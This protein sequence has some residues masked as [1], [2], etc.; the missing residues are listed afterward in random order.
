M[1]PET[2]L[3]ELH[4]VP[5]TALQLFRL[6]IQ[7][8][9]EI[10]FPGNRWY[11][12]KDGDP[13]AYALMT[14]HYSFNAYADGRRQDPRY[15]N[16]HLF[17]GPG[18]KMVLM[19]SDCLALFV[20]RKFNDASGQQGINCSVF[21]NEGPHLSSELILEAEALAWAQWPDKRLYTYIDPRRVSANPGYCFK[22][23]GWIMIGV[24]KVNKL[25]ILEKLPET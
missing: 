2:S 22:C 24:T 9:K 15:R 3:Y 25:H 20:W 5:N 16:R 8:P 21:R 17:V 10:M 19:T 1:R 12:T 7:D 4:D 11:P 6:K 18:Y 13:A 23:A 14:K